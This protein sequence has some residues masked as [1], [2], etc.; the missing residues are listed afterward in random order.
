[1][2]DF[3]A[4]N[5]W[6]VDRGDGVPSVNLV[7]LSFVNPLRLLNKANDAETVDG[8]PVGMTPEIVDYFKSHGIRVALSIGG[9][10]YTDDWATA[11]GID[12]TQLGWNAAEL[13]Q[14]LGVGIEIDYEE[15]TD[16]DLIGLQAFIDAYRS[17][18]P[19]DRT[20]RNHAA[21]LT[22]DFAAGDRYLQDLTRTATEDWLTHESPVLDYANA[23]VPA[24]QP[25]SASRAI[26]NWQE[27][28]DGKPQYA[29]PILPLAPS[30]FAVSLYLVDRNAIPEC[31]DFPNS[32]QYDTRDWVRTVA[33]NGA[34]TTSGTL[35]YM[36]WASEC[37]NDRNA[38]TTPPDSCEGGMGA[39]SQYFDIPVPMPPLREALPAG[40]LYAVERA[41]G[42][43][44]R[45]GWADVDGE[46][47]Y[48]IYRGELL[49][50]F[51]Y[52]HDTALACGLPAN[53]TTWVSPDDQETDQPS[54]YY[55]VVPRTGFGRDW[56]FDGAGVARPPSVAP[57]P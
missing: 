54:Y 21:R 17:V 44:L 6:I 18:L 1:M 50:P 19:Y 13:A 40:A 11:L 20:G 48:E 2:A 56:G 5:R 14:N 49:S 33:P 37:S 42:G 45:F 28:V 36:F 30:K 32:L 46:E 31:N 47:A 10:T 34:G 9:F 29:P 43:T 41:A 51:Y 12:A 52:G 53:T 7:V 26:E 4:K 24:R 25:S 39:A 55:L 16:P 3:D 27:H 57:C 8:V 35:G 15:N 23:M 22:L 38:C